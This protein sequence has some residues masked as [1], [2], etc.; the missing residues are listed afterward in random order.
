MRTEEIDRHDIR[1]DADDLSILLVALM[2]GVDAGVAL[3]TL[4][5]GVLRAA[6]AGLPCLVARRMV[7]SAGP[8]VAAIGRR[9]R[10]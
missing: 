1:W 9:D 3:L 5:I 10:G 7:G 2:S 4:L 8:L 6:L